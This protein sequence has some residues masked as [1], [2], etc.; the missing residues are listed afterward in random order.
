[1]TVQPGNC[2]G[3]DIGTYAVKMLQASGG[4]IGLSSGNAPSGGGGGGPTGSIAPRP[5]AIAGGL[6]MQPRAEA[7]P[8]AVAAADTAVLAQPKS[9]HEVMEL[10]ADAREAILYN[11][12]A[13]HVHLVRFEQGVVEFRPETQ[14][15]RDLSTRLGQF[16][17]RVTGQRWMVGVSREPGAPT[18]RQQADARTAQLRAD[19]EAHPMVKAAM[20]AFPG[21]RIERIVEKDPPIPPPE[22]VVAEAETPEPAALYEQDDPGPF[23]GADAYEPDEDGDDR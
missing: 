18:L 6:A 13:L 16:L 5:R 3:I 1:M 14:A 23:V 10:I 11:E 22:L 19:V 17:L 4:S 12:I 7:A 8:V 20:A 15:P 21:A 9:F 2:V